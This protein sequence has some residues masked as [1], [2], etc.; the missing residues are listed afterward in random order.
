VEAG[1]VT[2]SPPRAL[3]A[4]GLLTALTGAL[5]VAWFVSGWADVRGRQRAVRDAPRIAAEQRGAEL[6]HELRGELGAIMAREVERPYFQYQNLFHDPLASAMASHELKD[7]AL[8]LD[9]LEDCL[10]Q[11]SIV[12]IT[13]PDPVYCALTADDFPVGATVVDCWR[14]MASALSNHPNIRYVPLGRSVDDAA[15]TDRLAALWAA[16][17]A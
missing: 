3:Y 15:N 11:A 8:V 7:Q 14:I 17:R 10:A 13:T 5:L 6:A 9:S 1:P 12:I 4:A 16:P 2:A